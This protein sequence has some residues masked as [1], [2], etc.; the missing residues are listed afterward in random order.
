M[1]LP[2]GDQAAQQVGAAQERAV[3]RRRAADDDVVAA[4]GAGVA[5]VEHEL[6]G[7][8]PGLV[9]VLVEAGGDLHHLLPRAGRLDVDLDDAGIGG[10]L[11]DAEARIGG[12]RVAFQTYRQLQGGGRLLDGGDQLDVVVGALQRRHE[13]AQVAVASLE[14]DG[15]AHRAARLGRQPLL[16]HRL[17]AGCRRQ[18]RRR[19]VGTRRWRSVRIAQRRSLAR[20]DRQGCSTGMT[21]AAARAAPRSA[22]GSRAASRPA[23]GP[24]GRGG[25][26]SARS[27]SAPGRRARSS[28]GPA[29]P[30]RSACR[31]RARRPGRAAP[32]PPGPP[33]SSR[34][35]RRSPAGCAR[36]RC[37]AAGPRRPARRTPDRARASRP[38]PLAKRSASAMKAGR[39][40]PSSA[41]SDG[42]RPQRL[43][44]AAPEQRV[45]PARQRSRPDTT[46]PGRSAAGRPAR[47]GRAAGRSAR[48]RAAAWPGR[49]RRCSTRRR[50]CRRSRRTSA[51]RRRS[52][53]RRSARSALVDLLAGDHDPLPLLVGVGLGDPRR[54]AD[55][56]D[57][58][59]E[60]E[61][62]V[63][64]RRRC[65]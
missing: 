23:P 4:A 65:R 33:A 1:V 58:H 29:G 14:R 30:S 9:R 8:E 63:C 31:G 5:A 62:D 27:S 2:V 53:A 20:T 55:P 12:R 51:R 43:A 44:V 10:D 17:A 47:S 7:A 61:L 46:C 59:R 64:R 36:G 60:V 42:S 25:T 49:R 21:T 41:T 11:D 32:A 40:P 34:T 15:G 38:V 26:T 48:R 37:R 24:C 57:R 50:P 45:G 19:L 52:G 18:R 16:D 54:L 35:D 6:L 56:L 39:L 28:A 3:R 13:D 22:A